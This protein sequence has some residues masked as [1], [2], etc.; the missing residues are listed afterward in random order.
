MKFITMFLLLFLACCYLG[1]AQNIRSMQDRPYPYEVKYADLDDSLQIAYV[2]EGAG[3][4][5][6]LF[7]HGLGSN[8]KAWTKNI[9]SL[10]AQYR[11]IA[12]DLPGYGR[13]S[14]REYPYDM[15]FFAHTVRRFMDTL[16]LERVNLVGHSM[17]GQVATHVV[18]ADERSIVGLILIAPAGFETFTE[19]ES[20]WLQSVYTA[21]L[22]K[23]TPEEQIVKNFEINFYDMPDDA[24]FM[25][26]DRLQMR[27]TAAYDQY[28][29]M[30]PQC[31]KGML[32]QAVFDRLPEIELPTLVVFGEDDRLIPNRLL[33]PALTTA[34]VAKSG[35]ERLGQHTLKMIPEA[36]H[37]VQ[38]EQHKLVNNAILSFL[39]QP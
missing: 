8:L 12:I 17:G 29:N 4:A 16:Q 13:S 21:E 30:I 23:A 10:S 2:D 24:R 28:C 6:L 32:E 5:T 37:F 20:Q 36:G 25:I 3:P 26:E 11:C 27:Q 22:I 19:Q 31:V 1:Q 39:R 14:L 34:T 35:A 15:L 18:L 9:D 38:W 7:I 33:H